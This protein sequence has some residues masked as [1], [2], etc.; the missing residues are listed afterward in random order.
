MLTSIE[1]I[2]FCSYS[3]FL[4]RANFLKKKKKIRGRSS[5]I[6]AC[7]P[8]SLAD[9][10]AT[11]EYVRARLTIDNHSQFCTGTRNH[12]SGKTRLRLVMVLI[13]SGGEQGK[14]ELKCRVSKMGGER[15]A[16]SDLIFQSVISKKWQR[17][18]TNRSPYSSRCCA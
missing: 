14:E 13:G 3:F 12:V 2:F 16:D 18:F 15:T 5:F 1:T 6:Y 7:K 9:W 8:R 10:T 11:L 17:C 4:V